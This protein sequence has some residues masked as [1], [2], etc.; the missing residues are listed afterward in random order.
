M[1][2]DEEQ[3]VRLM[4]TA[5]RVVVIV[6]IA[7]RVLLFCQP[8]TAAYFTLENGISQCVLIYGINHDCNY[9]ISDHVHYNC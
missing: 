7:P 8:G 9:G 2:D 3:L 4:F 5:A 1:I 6:V